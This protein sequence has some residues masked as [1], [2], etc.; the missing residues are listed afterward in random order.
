MLNESNGVFA[1]SFV[2]PQAEADNS[3]RVGVPALAALC[4]EAAGRHAAA[5]GLGIADVLENNQAW[6]L[7]RMY[8]ELERQPQAGQTLAIRTWPCRMKAGTTKRD[9]CLADSTGTPLGRATSLWAIVDLQT[10]HMLAA[11]PWLAEQVRQCPESVLAFP[12]RPRGGPE[13]GCTNRCTVL[14]R[15]ADLD[16]HGHVNNIRILEWGL[17]AVPGAVRDQRLASAVDIVFKQECRDGD[18]IQVAAGEPSPGYWHHTLERE[19]DGSTVAVMQ[20]WWG[21]KDNFAS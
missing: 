10:R 15:R 3:G 14:A 20:T 8:L 16:I 19:Q 2:L 6:F 12:G 18:R 17:A 4:Q 11:G 5:M 21:M 1:A 13:H 9:F 7:L